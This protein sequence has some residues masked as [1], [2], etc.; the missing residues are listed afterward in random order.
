MAA[1]ELS[2]GVFEAL[3]E[4]AIPLMGPK[5]TLNDAIEKV[6]RIWLENC[7]DTISAELD[8][9]SVDEVLK[10]I[11]VPY[12]YL[13]KEIVEWVKGKET[14]AHDYQNSGWQ[15]VEEVGVKITL[16]SDKAWREGYRWITFKK[17]IPMRGRREIIGWIEPRNYG[18][19]MGIY[20]PV[21]KDDVKL[22]IGKDPE[23]RFA[24]K[25]NNKYVEIKNKIL[26]MLERAFE[27]L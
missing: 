18:F 10:E 9:P 13:S 20:D 23:L 6:I 19:L 25:G 11:P 12:R 15:I 21:K 26:S 4:L 5:D 17:E 8:G 22:R 3:K 16:P 7:R 24:G 2:K 1:I 14:K 27:A